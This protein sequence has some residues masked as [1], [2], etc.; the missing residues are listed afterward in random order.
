M[1]SRWWRT[2]VAV[3]FRG[4]ELFPAVAHRDDPFAACLFSTVTG[5]IM[6]S[7]LSAG[8][9]A[10]FTLGKMW[11]YRLVGYSLSLNDW[12]SAAFMWLG[13][14][15]YFVAFGFCGP[16]VLGGLH[17]L[18]LLLLGGV[19]EHRGYAHTVRVAA[20]AYAASLLVVP[21]PVVGPLI[22]FSL[23]ALNHVTGYDAVHGCGGGKAFI[24]WLL[25]RFG[26]CC[27]YTGLFLLVASF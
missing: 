15:T 18:A 5:A 9:V 21:I 13:I 24:A 3:N 6:G 11:V 20:Y 26:C 23:N 14:V 17:H 1:L 4:R 19:G 10:L 2:M 25:P 16:W 22:G 8:I 7:L 27:C 12:S